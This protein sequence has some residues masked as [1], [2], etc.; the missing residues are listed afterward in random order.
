VEEHRM[1]IEAA[2]IP[3]TEDQAH[4]Q[5]VVEILLPIMVADKILQAE[6]AVVAVEVAAVLM[7]EEVQAGETDSPVNIRK[8]KFIIYA[9][10]KT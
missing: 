9:K 2:A 8:N 3:Q 4:H 6:E 10:I 7:A 1:V 5:A